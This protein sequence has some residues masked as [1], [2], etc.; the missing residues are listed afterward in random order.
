MIIAGRDRPM[1]SKV[2]V[3]KLEDITT[4]AGSFRAFKIE[5]FDLGAPLVPTPRT[6]QVRWDRIYYYSPQ[7]GSIIKYRLESEAG[8]VHD[9]ELVKL[10]AP[11]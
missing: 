2:E 6:T 3:T 7:V 5:R 1:R 10:G 4:P 9:V 8:H 11:R